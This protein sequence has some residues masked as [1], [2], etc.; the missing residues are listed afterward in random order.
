MSA[1]QIGVIPSPENPN[2]KIFNRQSSIGV[3][4]MQA[5]LLALFRF[6]VLTIWLPSAAPKTPSVTLESQVTA[7]TGMTHENF[8]YWLRPNGVAHGRASR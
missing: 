5:R 1:L 3:S 8:F 6:D 7:Y 2:S 4:W